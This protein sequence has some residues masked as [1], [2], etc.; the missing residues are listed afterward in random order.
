MSDSSITP[1]VEG[2][3]VERAVTNPLI[4][5]GVLRAHLDKDKVFGRG[6]VPLCGDP[7]D[8]S[9]FW[10]AFAHEMPDIRRLQ[11]FTQRFKA[12]K[13]EDNFASGL[14][15]DGARAALWSSLAE[16]MSG[17]TLP[18]DLPRI[19]FHDFQN[20]EQDSLDPSVID[21]V[22]PS[23]KAYQCVRQVKTLQ[24][25]DLQG[26][27]RTYTLA[28]HTNTLPSDNFVI[29]CLN[30]PLQKKSDGRLLFSALTS[31]TAELGPIVGIAKMIAKTSEGKKD[32]FPA[33]TGTIRAY[34]KLK[35]PWMAASIKGLAMRL[36]SHLL[37]Y[38]TPRKLLYLGCDAHT[39]AVHSQDFPLDSEATPESEVSDSSQSAKGSVQSGDVAEGDGEE[40][41]ARLAKKRKTNQKNGEDI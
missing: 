25:D 37:W 19:I 20:N 38:G 14:P 22:Y 31:I 30:L 5:K 12:K 39:E 18:N 2:S 41:G 28:L 17:C 6:L 8:E 4:D 15:Q 33:F 3:P 29:D 1:K 21:L 11:P 27:T 32:T 40:E 24:I 10:H 16:V 36:P 26:H 13:A 7:P 35:R 23:L 9:P 34:V